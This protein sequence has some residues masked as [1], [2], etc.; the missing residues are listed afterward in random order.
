MNNKKYGYERFEYLY[1]EDTLSDNERVLMTHQAISNF[2][3]EVTGNA[4]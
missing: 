2:F 1:L 3:E 4:N